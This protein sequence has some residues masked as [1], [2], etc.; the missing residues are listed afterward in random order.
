MQKLIN[1]DTEQ[2]VSDPQN[3][4]VS[5]LEDKSM[6]EQSKPL[7]LVDYSNLFGEEFRVPDGH[8]D[9]SYL[10]ILDIGAVEEGILHVIYSC[11]A[12]VPYCHMLY[13]SLVLVLMSIFAVFYVHCF[14]VMIYQLLDF[15]ATRRVH[16]SML[17]LELVC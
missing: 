11:A 12:Q 16:K 3:E 4:V 10:N 5:V 7:T 2:D 8:W 17:P 6:L 15:P 1:P 13:K 14:D 9:C